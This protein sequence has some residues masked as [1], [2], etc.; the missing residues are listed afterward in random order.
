MRTLAPLVAVL[1]A[2]AVSQSGEMIAAPVPKDKPPPSIDGKYTLLSVAN[3]TTA[4]GP[5]GKASRS[6]SIALVGPA[7]ITKNEISFE[8][9]SSPSGFSPA[10]AAAIAAGNHTTMEYTLDPTK[11]PMTIDVDIVN[12]RGKKSKSLGLVEINGKHL[13]IAL[14]K[15]GDERPKTTDEA[16]GVTVYYFK[17]EPPP[18]RTEFR[19]VTLTIGKEE[20]VEKELNRL[21]QDGYEL[22]STTQPTAPD[23]KSSPTTVHL[24]LKRTVKLPE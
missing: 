23:A 7:T 6:G 24:I 8:G 12:V 2:F 11:S 1:V 20:A 18:P 4:V 9:R 16:E 17:K 21:A 5:G 10:A 13:I 14:A 3:S 19:I 22:A 15:E